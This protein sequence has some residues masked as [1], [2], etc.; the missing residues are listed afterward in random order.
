MTH[1][2][3]ILYY[4]WAIGAL[5]LAVIWT[6]TLWKGTFVAIRTGTGFAHANAFRGTLAINFG[7]HPAGYL[8]PGVPFESY[9]YVETWEYSSSG[10]RP[11][12]Y[13]RFHYARHQWDDTLG[14][15]TAIQLWNPLYF[16]ILLHTA[17]FTLL[18]LL[19]NRHYRHYRK[20]TAL[21]PQGS[22]GVPPAP[23]PRSP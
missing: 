22:V 10:E 4:P 11:S 18:Y 20:K 5:L 3:R 1:W 9:R 15:V 6:S 13:G 12:F 7:K 8:A 19:L 2:K 16:L 14:T 17:L 21:L 23:Q